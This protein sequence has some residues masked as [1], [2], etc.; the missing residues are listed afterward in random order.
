M[1]YHFDVAG[2]NFDLA[3]K[4]SAET[5]KH[6]KTLQIPKDTLKRVAIAM[7]EAELNMIVHADGGTIDVEVTEDCIH[8]VVKD[9]GPGIPDLDKAMAE[10][11][12]TANNVY[13]ELGY[14]AGMGL[15][16]ILRNTDKLSIESVPNEGTIITMC[17]NYAK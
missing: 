9:N 12:S 3:G 15:S 4:A 5:K 6:L 13:V 14:G 7:Y 17:I 2:D 11:F 16:N 8:V 1:K 10:G